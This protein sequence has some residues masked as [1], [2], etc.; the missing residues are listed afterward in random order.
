MKSCHYVFIAKGCETLGPWVEETSNF[1]IRMGTSDKGIGRTPHK[2]I[3]LPNTVS[4]DSKGKWILGTLPNS[5]PIN[6][7]PHL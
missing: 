1:I 7:F 5:I 4:C 2:T 6:Q 3:L